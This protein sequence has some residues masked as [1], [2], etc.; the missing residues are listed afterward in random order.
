MLNHLYVG[1]YEL[2]VII[3]VPH[4][5]KFIITLHEENVKM[6]I[7]KTNYVFSARLN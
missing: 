5:H 6:F 4:S 2:C 7:P 3:S 1:M